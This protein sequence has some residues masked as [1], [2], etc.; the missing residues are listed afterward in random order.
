MSNFYA[1][2]PSLVVPSSV[3]TYA[4]LAAFPAASTAGNGSLAIALDTGNLYESNGASWVLL[5]EPS[6]TSAI[7]ALT[8]DVSAT[9]PGSVPATVNLVGG[10]TASAVNSATILANAATSANTASAIA[11]RDG[12]GNIAVSALT[13]TALNLTGASGHN[14]TIDALGKIIV[15]NTAGG[16]DYIV[17]GAG[18]TPSMDFYTGGALALSIAYAS[19]AATFSGSIAASNFSGTSSGT[20]TG[21]VTLG[22]ASGLSLAGQVLSLALSSTSTTGA[23]SSTDWNTFNGKQ[24]SGSYITALTGDVTATGPGSSAATVAKIQSTVVSGTTGSGNVAFS[25]SP[26]FTGTLSAAAISASSTIG[27]SNFSGTSSGTNT[28][29]Q[30][31]TLTGDVTGSGTGSFAATVAKIQSTTVS[32]TTGTTNVVFS[33]APTLTGLTSIGSLTA[34]STLTT[35]GGGNSM[36][37]TSAAVAANAIAYQTAGSNRWIM[38]LDGVAESGSDAGSNWQLRARTDAGGSIDNPVVITRATGGAITATRPIVTT[39]TTDSTSTA[40]GS[41]KSS[42]G[43]GFAKNITTGQMLLTPGYHFRNTTGNFTVNDST[44]FCVVDAGAQATLTVTLPATPQD[45]Q[46]LNILFAGAITTLT[47]SPSG[48]QTVNGAPATATANSGFTWFYRSA[49]TTW[50]RLQ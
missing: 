14:L 39:S 35:T 44:N 32:G 16:N 6:A 21:D 30:T 41:L 37:L 34:T 27:A 43:A 25:A 40:T 36:I 26:T 3:P 15:N 42:G 12:S 17:A 7:T 10:S 13:S 45:G 46:Q 48:G 28:G 20:N 50:Y 5:A 23:L 47:V 4:N 2:Y 49:N 11:R 8:G 38:G 18:G 1:I 9:G 33:A 24:A 31:I 29:D 19:Q 22:T